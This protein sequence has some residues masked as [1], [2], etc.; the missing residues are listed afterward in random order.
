MISCESCI[1][2]PD[3]ERMLWHEIWTA[4]YITCLLE[5]MKE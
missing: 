2:W 1:Y 3:I 5:G 4:R